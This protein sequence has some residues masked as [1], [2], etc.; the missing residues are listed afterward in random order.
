MSKNRETPL[1][2]FR[3]T[4]WRGKRQRAESNRLTLKLLL[5]K[6]V[7]GLA[8]PRPGRASGPDEAGLLPVERLV[9]SRQR[10][11]R[12]L[13]LKQEAELERIAGASQPSEEQLAEKLMADQEQRAEKLLADVRALGRLPHRMKKPVGDEQ[14]AEN[15]LANRLSKARAN[16]ELSKEQEAELGRIA[17]A[18]QPGE[19]QLAEKLLRDLVLARTLEDAEGCLRRPRTA[20]KVP[21]RTRCS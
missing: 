20:R 19:E 12:R 5:G 1:P 4:N 10:T 17:G 7:F 16:K 11:E 15:N 9:L 6:V 18:S 21:R 3:A 2:F 13:K 8:R 14:I